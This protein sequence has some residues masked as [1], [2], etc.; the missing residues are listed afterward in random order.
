MRW[1]VVG[2]VVG[3][4]VGWPLQLS[5]PSTLTRYTAVAILGIL[6][7]VFG[8]LKAEVEEQFDLKV[9]LSGLVVN[10]LLAIGITYMGDRLGLDLY[11]AATVVFTFRIFENISPIRRFVLKEWL[12]GKPKKRF[13]SRQ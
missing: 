6:D 13:R 5:L 2:I 9:F 11:L 12:N 8:G 4:L 7:A 1:I 10:I 3:L